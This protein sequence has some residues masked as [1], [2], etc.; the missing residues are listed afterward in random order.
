[1]SALVDALCAPSGDAT[2][3]Y[4]TFNAASFLFDNSST[5]FCDAGIALRVQQHAGSAPGVVAAPRRKRRRRAPSCKSK[6]EAES[7]RMTHIAVERNRRRQ[8]NE[9][10]AVLRSLM[11]EAYVQRVRS[12]TP[13]L[14][15]YTKPTQ[16][17][18]FF[19]LLLFKTEKAMP[20]Q[21]GRI[22]AKECLFRR[23]GPTITSC[24]SHLSFSLSRLNVTV[25]PPH[26]LLFEFF[27]QEVCVHPALARHPEKPSIYVSPVSL[28]FL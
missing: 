11:P 28:T 23:R 21:L 18:V 20:D 8:M 15:R 1:M 5:A 17:Q 24:A 25:H 4:D 19:F 6:E 22:M 2:L 3:I 27:V 12:H 14:S 13:R 10:L 26:T 9:Y 7:Q 16:L